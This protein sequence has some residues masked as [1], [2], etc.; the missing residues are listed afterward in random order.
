MDPQ[1]NSNGSDQYHTTIPEELSGKRF[2]VALATLFPEFSRSRLQS[3][4]RSG[5]A[6]IDGEK[7]RPRD[8]VATGE[9]VRL[10]AE[11]E[12]EVQ[13]VA[14]PI[15]L[16]ILH[17]DDSII[18][19]DKPAG[20]V[21]HPAV[22]NWGGTLVNALLHHDK[23]LAEVPRAGIVHRLDKD[24]SGV[25]VV[26]KT[27]E[28]HT[29]LVRQLQE[30]SM[31]R[32]YQAICKG[33]MTAGGTVD[34]PIGRHRVDRKKMAVV[35]NGKPAVT[36]YR[37]ME[38]F[39]SHTHVRLSLETGRTHQIRVHMEHIRFALLGDPVYGHRL[40]I[41]AGS[42]EEMSETLRVFKRQALHAARLGL[43]HPLSGELI[44]F[45]AP[46]PEDMVNIIDILREDREI[47]S[48]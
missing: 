31:S 9:E 19:V 32:E 38:K 39:R 26:A 10:Q 15:P 14:E 2:D 13:W 16:N 21:V 7:R 48:Q 1:Q 33:V 27:L 12:E 44:E 30:R 25:L 41:P 3:W 17:E 45:E 46:L 42:S 5:D 47:N 20:M 11:R 28:A 24:T 23:T 35:E 29:D 6:L 37:V 4:I 40:Q 36:H 22:G 43:R 18:F 8:S 34:A